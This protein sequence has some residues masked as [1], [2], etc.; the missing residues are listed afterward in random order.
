[1][2]L[3]V[4]SLRKTYQQGPKKIEVIRDLS[5]TLEKGKT[6]AILGQSGSGKS[7]LL[8]LL[9]GL[10]QPEEGSIKLDGV[11]LSNL[12]EKS[13]TNLRA[14]KI[15]IIFQNFHLLPHLNALENIALSL[16][17][18]KKENAKAEALKWIEK[19]G[20]LDRKDHFPDQLS[21]G[22]KQR[23]AIARALAIGPDIILADEPS[24]SLDE[25]TG[26]KVMNLI[27]GLVKEEGSTLIL[28]THNKELAKECERTV[29]LIGG[30]LDEV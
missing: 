15:G 28:V 20:L 1:M 8:S 23:I 21:G 4:Q 24:G 7:T 18:L 11:D 25:E 2:I 6:L 14:Q 5:L 19:V 9:S 17:I 29:K 30:K 13:L 26:N 12:D 22:E 16:E 27:F 3:D 10:D